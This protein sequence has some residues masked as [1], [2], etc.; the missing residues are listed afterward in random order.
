M[1]AYNWVATKRQ[2][3]SW[4]RI[5]QEWEAEDV[6]ELLL[7]LFSLPVLPLV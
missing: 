2:F 5:V 4:P 7:C 1:L 6:R 3:V